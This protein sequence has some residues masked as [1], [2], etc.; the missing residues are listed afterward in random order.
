M[1]ILYWIGIAKISNPFDTTEQDAKHKI[2]EQTTTSSS[3]TPLQAKEVIVKS[4]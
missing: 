4:A 2:L 3:S 1:K